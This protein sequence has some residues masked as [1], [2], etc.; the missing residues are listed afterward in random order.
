M[1]PFFSFSL[2]SKIILVYFTICS[3]L[4]PWSVHLS[5]SQIKTNQRDRFRVSCAKISKLE[6]HVQVVP[7]KKKINLA[8]ST[9]CIAFQNQIP[10]RSPEKYV[11]YLIILFFRLSHKFCNNYSFPEESAISD[12]LHCSCAHK[13]IT[14]NKEE[15]STCEKPFLSIC[16]VRIW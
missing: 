1:F 2:K 9:F 11:H 8:G 15:Y 3:H 5:L 16:L 7:T 13:F 10:S 6:T 14:K 12:G 4:R